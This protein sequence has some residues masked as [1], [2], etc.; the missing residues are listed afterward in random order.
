MKLITK[1]SSRYLLFSILLLI[2]FGGITL[3]VLDFI[4]K[5]EIDEKLEHTLSNIEH[6]IIEKQQLTMLEPFVEVVEISN[7]S[8]SKT[9]SNV[10]L[11]IIHDE[12]VEEFRQLLVVETFHGI[13]YQITIRESILEKEDV[14]KAIALP[15]LISISLLVL[16]QYLLSI[17]I[18]KSVWAP[19]FANLE[20]LKQFQVQHKKPFHSTPSNIYEF[21][22]LNDV[23]AD[24]TTK[25]M[26]DYQTLKKFSEDAS[27][28]LQTPLAIIR[29]KLESFF[30]DD[31][32]TTEQV[33]KIQSIHHQV[34]RLTRLNKELLLLT[35]IENQQFN[36]FETI[37]LE[38][39]LK[40]QTTQFKELAELKDI[41]IQ[42]KIAGNWCI[43]SNRFLMEQLINNLFSNAI[44]HNH[45][46]GKIQII[47]ANDSLT[48][49]NTC[50]S[51][52][53]NTARIFDRFYKEKQT[54]ST[55]LG[56]A[57]VKQICDSSHLSIHYTFS[58]EMHTFT[59]HQTSE[60]HL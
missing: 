42:L 34:N 16:I 18:S 47:L 12:G 39:L 45:P 8:N 49:S 33:E 4:L 51:K 31:H 38:Q 46:K 11:P 9:F 35:Q 60:P 36:K 43:E 7:S 19:F 54:G 58:N 55:G 29:S 28:E 40:E 26:N 5:E 6:Y 14:L 25:V 13:S 21:N 27:H 1:I 23:I 50:N 53:S 56:L 10:H 37:E 30:N 52:I 17:R 32:L 59:I 2:A 24:L 15:I 48:F 3:T 22:E 44:K 41:A 20:K 57:I